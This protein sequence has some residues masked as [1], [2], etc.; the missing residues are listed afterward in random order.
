VVTGSCHQ[1]LS[2]CSALAGRRSPF[3]L[4]Q[5]F[6]GDGLNMCTSGV[7]LRCWRAQGEQGA[8]LP[9]GITMMGVAEWQEA[10]WE[11]TVCLSDRP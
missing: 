6:L 4:S 5:L 11:R 9:L 8:V 7:G 10:C 3:S 1:Q 2:I